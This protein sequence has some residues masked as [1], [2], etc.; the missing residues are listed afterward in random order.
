MI[1][2]KN[3]TFSY[4]Y[5]SI[6]DNVNLSIKKKE[7]I[8]IIGHNGSGKTTFV[9]LLL[10]LLRPKSGKTSRDIPENLCAR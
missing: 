3:L 4:G 8:S 7:F 2:I 9:K 5:N 10:G 1:S 6:L